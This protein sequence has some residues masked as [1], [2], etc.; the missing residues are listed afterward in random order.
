MKYLQ[1]I[2]AY[3]GRI[4][5][6]KNLCVNN[7][8]NIY[9]YIKIHSR[10][11]SVVHTFSAMSLYCCV[12]YVECMMNRTSGC[13]LPNLVSSCLPAGTKEEHRIIGTAGS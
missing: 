3:Y 4:S 1:Y 7:R 8:I 9:L 2:V 13:S 5:F 10:A 11:F 12:M 6:A